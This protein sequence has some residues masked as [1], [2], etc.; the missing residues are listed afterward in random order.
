MGEKMTKRRVKVEGT[1]YRRKDGRY[2]GE[3]VDTNGR[4]RYISAKSKAEVRQ[5]LRKLLENREYSTRSLDY[6]VA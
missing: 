4:N 5:K 1:V 3:Y 6:A 2:M